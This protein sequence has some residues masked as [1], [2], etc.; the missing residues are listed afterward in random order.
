[1]QAAK[2]NRLFWALA[3]VLVLA[4]VAV[5]ALSLVLGSAGF[6]PSDPSFSLILWQ[7]RLPRLLLAFAVGGML[8]VAGVYMQ[9][10]FRNALAEPYI[11]GVSAGAGLGAVIALVALPFSVF[12]S[13][14]TLPLAAFIGGLAITA[15]LVGL[16]RDPGRTP[17]RLLLLGIALGTLAAAVMAFIL[18]RFPERTLK[19]ALYWLYGS[20]TGADYA[21]GAIASVVL[22]LALIWG[23]RQHRALDALLLGHE[24]AHNL[25]LNV[26]ALSRS[27]LVAATLLASVAVAFSGI[28][29]FV[30]L[31]VPHSVRLI[32]GAAHH[33]VIIISVLA[34][35]AL[36]GLVDLLARTLL[37]P[38]EIPL[39]IITSLIGAPFFILLLLRSRGE[40]IG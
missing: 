6:N 8:A 34:G 35:M 24:E 10:L 29:S 16:L 27:L 20:L 4:L 7:L 9:C 17:L 40:T 14:V 22:L 25:G 19:G 30:G 18:L 28:V 21:Q 36:L 33:R 38:G 32:V 37:T 5:G 2:P 31:V 13:I 11:T 3:S 1:M 23:L 12:A 15:L 39:S 26:R